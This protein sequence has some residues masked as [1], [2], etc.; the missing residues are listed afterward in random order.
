[1]LVTM[2]E[3]LKDAMEEGYAVCASNVWYE[4]S[5]QAALD[6][7]E[8]SGSPLILNYNYMPN[9][10]RF[11]DYAKR[12]AEKVSVYLS[13]LTMI[14]GPHSKRQCIVFTQASPLLWQTV[15]TCPLRRIFVR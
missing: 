12:W 1:M 4:W 9:V 11:M 8:E 13:P 15:Q 10:Y 7:A 14:T 2:K 5:T 6:A 3:L